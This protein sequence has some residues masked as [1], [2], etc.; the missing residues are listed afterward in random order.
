M[1]RS[2]HEVWLHPLSITQSKRSQWT[3]CHGDA[4]QVR[5]ELIPNRCPD[6]VMNAEPAYDK[7]WPLARASSASGAPVLRSRAVP[8]ITNVLSVKHFVL[9]QGLLGLLDA[10]ISTPVE[11]GGVVPGLWNAKRKT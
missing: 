10:H 8:M 5:P 2:G 1:P 11:P 4:F 7:S 3:L 9:S 6:S